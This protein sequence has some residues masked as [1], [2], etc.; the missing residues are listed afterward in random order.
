[1]EKPSLLSNFLVGL[2]ASLT[3]G[4]FLM[5]LSQKMAVSGA[6]RSNMERAMNH[7]GITKNQYMSCPECYPLPARGTGLLRREE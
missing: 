7:Y 6:P 4:L 1:M 5:F 2:T 3:T